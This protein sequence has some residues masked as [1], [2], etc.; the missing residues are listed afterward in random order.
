MLWA[1]GV[2]PTLAT[3]GYS[4]ITIFKLGANIFG[5]YAGDFS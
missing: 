5:I 3:S 1:G 4:A 2:E